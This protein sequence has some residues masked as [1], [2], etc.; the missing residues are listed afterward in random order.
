[1][2]ESPMPDRKFDKALENDA[3]TAAT[4]CL[5]SFPRYLAL[6]RPRLLSQPPPPTC[7][8]DTVHANTTLAWKVETTRDGRV[9]THN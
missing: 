8:N 6:S 1:M 9:F 7:A 4:I 2:G 5:V 3:N